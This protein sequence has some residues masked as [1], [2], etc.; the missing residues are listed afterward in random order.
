MLRSGEL[1][2]DVP[3]AEE[4]LDRHQELRAEVTDKE[5]KLDTLQALGR[6][7]LPSAKDPEEISERQQ[8]LSQEIA[9]LKD[10]WEERNK[11]LKQSSVLQ[12]ILT[13]K[14]LNFITNRFFYVML[15]KSILVLLLK[16]HSFL[17]T[18]LE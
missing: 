4:M 13:V 2:R 9:Q 1:P 17:M 14:I 8:E 6:R 16:R 15:N 5:E 12:V 10:S 7:A 3:A 18:M 11:Q